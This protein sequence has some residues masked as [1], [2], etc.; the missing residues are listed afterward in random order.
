[1]TT[2]QMPTA[3]SGANHGLNENPPSIFWW[4][5]VLAPSRLFPVCTRGAVPSLPAQ[6]LTRERVLNMGYGHLGNH[7]LLTRLSWSRGSSCHL[8]LLWDTDA[9]KHH[10]RW[11]REVT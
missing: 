3:P 1:M 8:H 2:V 9:V 5:G 7:R 4:F 11:R 10:P 6:P